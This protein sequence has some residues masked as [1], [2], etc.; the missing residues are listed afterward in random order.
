MYQFQLYTAGGV[1][2]GVNIYVLSI[3]GARLITGSTV[4]R[5]FTSAGIFHFLKTDVD[6]AGGLS[7]MTA[8]DLYSPN[9]EVIGAAYVDQFRVRGCKD[10]SNSED[11]AQL[12]TEDQIILCDK[13]EMQTQLA[14]WAMWPPTNI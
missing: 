8:I 6:A 5:V 14:A 2:L 11:L 13:S 1:A 7:S 4:Y 3:L 10:V 12:I 9:G